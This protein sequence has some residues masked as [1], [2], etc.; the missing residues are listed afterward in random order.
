LFCVH[1]AGGTATCYLHLARALDKNWSVYGVQL[2][3]KPV[4]FDLPSLAAD[5]VTAIRGVQ[6]QGPYHLLGWSVGGIIALEVARQFELQGHAVRHVILLDSY[7]PAMLGMSVAHMGDTMR[8]FTS[9]LAESAGLDPSIVLP[10]DLPTQPEAL[11]EIVALRHALAGLTAAR[12][13][14]I[15]RNFAA[16]LS[17]FH[18]HHPQSVDCPVTLYRATEGKEHHRHGLQEFMAG[19]QTQD[20]VGR[21]GTIL[22]LPNVVVLAQKIDAQLRPKRTGW[23]SQVTRWLCHLSRGRRR[24]ARRQSVD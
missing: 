7:T 3:T 22:L 15:Y 2:A 17:A 23:M 20:V 19:L 16:V 14:Q 9:D 12:L 4:P 6:P 1:P 10:A 5:H 8:A 21:H 24:L 13:K 11:L 18:S